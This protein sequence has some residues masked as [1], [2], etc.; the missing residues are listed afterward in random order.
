M[1]G[2]VQKTPLLPRH[3]FGMKRKTLEAKIISYFDYSQDVAAILQYL[4]VVMLRNS[5]VVGDFS[6]L[7]Q[8]L[9]CDLF[10][11][12]EPSDTLRKYCG[13][14]KDYFKNESDWETVI[15]R[16]FVDK[17]EYAHFAKEA[18]SYKKLLDT[19]GKGSC[20]HPELALRI[21][22]VF[23]DAEGKK[24][25]L[26]IRDAD[27]TRTK[28]EVY[29]ILEI[30]T[31]VTIFSTNDG[32]RRFVR[33]VKASRPG[34]QETFEEGTIEEK[35]QQGTSQK[36]D[37]KIKKTVEI[38]IPEGI[39]LNT[40]SDRELLALVRVGHPDVRSLEDIQLVFTKQEE[41]GD[42]SEER[43]TAS[44]DSGVDSNPLF[45]V[46]KESVALAVPVRVA[47][48]PAENPQK[49]KRKKLLT[50][51]EAYVQ[52]VIKKDYPT[53]KKGQGKKK[54]STGKKKKRK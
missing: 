7:C 11:V 25:T 41:K 36:A 34:T 3:L 16:L 44:V 28:T 24:H 9:I 40:L 38:V 27:E 35:L 12:A 31:T 49:R 39:D 18:R 50:P 29:R 14:F 4:V 33:L 5:L 48:P 6:F 20:K 52:S 37:A 22:S 21:V 10:L 1:K 46:S 15:G 2:K 42:G 26:T 43:Q 51:K 53:T 45:D 19:P 23:E 13:Y 8:E 32:V 54:R 17:E 47:D 30:L